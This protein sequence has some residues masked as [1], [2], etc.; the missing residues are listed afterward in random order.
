MKIL[1][2]DMPSG[3]SGDMTLGAF[4]DAG[5]P[6]RVLREGLAPVWAWWL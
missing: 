6:E 3:I 1:Y 2:I 4:L 5:V